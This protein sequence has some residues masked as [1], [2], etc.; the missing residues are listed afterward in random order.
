MNRMNFRTTSL[1]CAAT[2]AILAPASAQG[3]EKVVAWVPGARLV[4]PADSDAVPQ[5]GCRFGFSM[6]MSD[7]YAVIGAPD[8]RL[9][10]NDPETGETTTF[11]GAGAAFVFELNDATGEWTFL[12]RLVGPQVALMQ[13][14]CSVGIDSETE[15][16]VVG[17]WGY[18]R[19]QSFAGAAFVYRKEKDGWGAT[20]E[21]LGFGEETRAPSQVLAPLTLA[22]IDQ[23]GFS[24]AIN[25]GT[26]A[27]G[28]PLFGDSNTG[29][30]FMFDRREDGTYRQDQRIEPVG[31]GAND[32]SGTKVAISGNV[33]VVG[34]QNDDV[35]GRI[36]AGSA[37]VYTRPKTGEDWSE[38]TRLTAPTVA[39]GG[40]YGSSV[41]CFDGDD[42]KWIA[43]GSPTATSG[44]TTQRAGNGLAFVYASSNGGSTWTLDGTLLP[45]S[46][47]VNN[48]FGYAVA[49]SDTN[50]PQVMVGAPGYETAIASVV[51]K[52]GIVFTQIANAGAGFAFTRRPGAGWAIRSAGPVSGDLWSPSVVTSNSSMG[53][54]IATAP[55]L[56][57][58]SLCG[59]DT[60]TGQL[61]TVF[62]FEFK[63][64]PVGQDPGDAAGPVAG[65]LGPDGRPGGD[66]A[67]GDGSG[68]TGGGITGGGT[69]TTGI[70]AGPGAIETPLT[71]IRYEWGLIKGSAVAVNRD[72]IFLLQ[73]DGKH[74]NVRPEFRYFT[75]L[76]AGATLVGL[77]DLNGDLSGDVVWVDS[78]N[79]LKYWKRDEFTIVSTRTIDTLPAGYEAVLV[80]DTDGDRKEEIFLRD[81]DDPRQ[82]TVWTIEGGAIST[83][84]DFE[85]P[86]GDWELSLGAFTAR[87]AE[88]LLLRERTTGA[89]RVMLV[90]RNTASYPLLSTRGRNMR[91]AGVG[92]ANGDGQ[93]DL[94]WQGKD[95]EIDYMGQDDDGTFI[96]VGVKRAG[97]ANKPILDVRDWND[98]GTIDFWCQDGSRNFVMYG[99]V[100]DG[101]MYSDVCRDI[102][103]APGRVIGFAAR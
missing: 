44:A 15:D 50:P 19:N 22:A 81:I 80:A 98:D 100:V 83:S 43:I 11:N 93:A 86:E 23:F 40:G 74:S 91:L 102:G 70:T 35:Q 31:G 78:G 27:V 49:M 37:I 87:N 76:P 55:T 59:A 20:A 32:Q 95:V 1:A 54:S 39:A 9:A 57:M 24:V 53:R 88:D 94:I 46:D 69:P 14:G 8:V 61:G 73:T 90:D 6:A 65:P 28:C 64:A 72:R 77:G 58:F 68:G 71:P 60:P 103:N 45:R 3:P 66:D 10:F 56:P 34:V 29:A 12:Q 36:N 92:D 26:I 21:E 7:R 16:I 63:L 48:N 2:L 13:T 17:A 82:I 33:L 47:N 75:K 67:P 4:V 18:S 99:K 85:L 52:D 79:V 42:S 84:E 97:F 41:A 38:A 5:P 30:V 101:Y 96:R 62:P 89:V 25:R 51:G